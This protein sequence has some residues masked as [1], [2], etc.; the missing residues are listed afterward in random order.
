M[1]QCP[2]LFFYQQD[3][4]LAISVPSQDIVSFIS[5]NPTASKLRRKANQVKMATTDEIRRVFT[6]KE[7]RDT[8]F[9]GNLVSA[10]LE[11]FEAHVDNLPALFTDDREL[12]ISA[13]GLS[14]AMAQFW[15]SGNNSFGVFMLHGETSAEV[16]MEHFLTLL[17]GVPRRCP[18]GSLVSVAVT[19]STN[20]PTEEFVSLC[21]NLPFYRDSGKA[22]GGHAVIER[23]IPYPSSL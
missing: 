2:F 7:L 9:P 19:F 8:V 20:I 17:A 5:Q 1:Y 3:V 4:K 11:L 13:D 23:D 15:P 21:K 18:V 16:A 14:V 10:G 22:P 6:N 12:T